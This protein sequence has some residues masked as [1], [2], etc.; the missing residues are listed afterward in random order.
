MNDDEVKMLYSTNKE[1]ANHYDSNK[2][3]TKTIEYSFLVCQEDPMDT[4]SVTKIVYWD[5]YFK[6][7]ANVIKLLN[8]IRNSNIQVVT[9]K[10]IFYRENKT[11]L[12]DFLVKCYIDTLKKKEDI[13]QLLNINT[14]KER[15]SSYLTTFYNLVNNL[16]I[17]PLYDEYIKEL[18]LVTDYDRQIESK[19]EKPILFN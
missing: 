19:N 15:I 11:T 12:K 9:V 17:Y 3:V 18:N 2:N 6:D 16:D 8:I 1:I 14:T 5:S 7:Y 4:A 10:Q 13:E